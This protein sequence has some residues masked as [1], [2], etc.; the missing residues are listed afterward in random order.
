[1]E[2]PLP[3]LRIHA[4]DLALGYIEINPDAVKT[5]ALLHLIHIH[6]LAVDGIQRVV[7]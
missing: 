3:Q 1:M 5:D 4:D 2:P 6:L 7:Q